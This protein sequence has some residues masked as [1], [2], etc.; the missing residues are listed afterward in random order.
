MLLEREANDLPQV[1]HTKKKTHFRAIEFY[2][3]FFTVHQQASFFFNKISAM[4]IALHILE[5]SHCVYS[6]IDYEQSLFFLGQSSKTC[7]IRKWPRAWLKARDWR[8]LR[9]RVLPA[10]NLKKKRHCSQ[11]NFGAWRQQ[12]NFQTLLISILIIQL[13]PVV[14]KVN[15]AIHWINLYPLKSVMGFSNSYPLDSDLSGE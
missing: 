9:S 5:T 15:N 3:L 4:G 10:L 11:S 12:S 6:G 2:L 14:Q 1:S 8:G 13:A 7:E